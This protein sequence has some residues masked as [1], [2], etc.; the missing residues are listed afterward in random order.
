MNGVAARIPYVTNSWQRS[1]KPYTHANWNQGV[2]DCPGFVVPGGQ[3]LSPE[4]AAWFL[5]I[6]GWGEYAYN[7]IGTQ[8]RT[9]PNAPFG[10][11]GLGEVVVFKSPFGIENLHPVPEARVVAPSDM[12]A[13]ADS[14][15]SFEWVGD[16]HLTDSFVE[17]Y[18][19]KS[20][21]AARQSFRRR[22]TGRCNVLFVDGHIEHMKRSNFTCVLGRRCAGSIMITRLIRN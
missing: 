19:T 21:E 17:R 6:N 7:H 16:R 18:G 4:W 10:S 20:R 11:F 5:E 22:H 3:L 13:V 12:I 14:D 9:P 15:V 8:R 2:Y 1:L